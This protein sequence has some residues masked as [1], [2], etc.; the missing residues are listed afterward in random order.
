MG[1]DKGEAQMRYG[2]CVGSAC[3]RRVLVSLLPSCIALPFLVLVLVLGCAAAIALF[4]CWTRS[5]LHI[6]DDVRAL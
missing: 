2:S 1:K 4:D 6:I 3:L 5:T